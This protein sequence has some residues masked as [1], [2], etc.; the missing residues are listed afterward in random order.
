MGSGICFSFPW[1]WWRPQ[2]RVWQGWDMKS[3]ELPPWS[4]EWLSRKHSDHPA[5]AMLWGSTIYT[6][7]TCSEWLSQLSP[8]FELFQPKCQMYARRTL[9]VTPAPTPSP[10]FNWDLRHHGGRETRHHC[11]TRSKIPTRG[12]CK[13]NEIVVKLLHFGIICYAE[14]TG[15]PFRKFINSSFIPPLLIKLLLCGGDSA[16]EEHK[17]KSLTFQELTV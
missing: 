12:N 10:L 11:C 15:P 16:T 8:D 4:P 1:V 17:I 5:L 2:L 6:D 14:I 13:Y 9:Q 7:A 3:Q